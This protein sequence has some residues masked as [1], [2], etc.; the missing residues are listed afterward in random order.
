MSALY[1]PAAVSVGLFAAYLMTGLCHDRIRRYEKDLDPTESDTYSKIRAYRLWC[2]VVGILFAVLTLFLYLVL[3]RK[4]EVYHTAWDAIL[5]LLLVPMVIYLVIPK[6]RYM[7]LEDS[8]SVETKDWFRVYGCMTRG[9]IH[10]FLL[11]FF[12][13]LLVL[14]LIDRSAR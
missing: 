4:K 12:L 3:I 5:I 8:S 14:W 2:F 9:M 11:G 6:P 1:F 10:G 7:L 13:S